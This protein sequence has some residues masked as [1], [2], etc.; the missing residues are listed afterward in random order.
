MEPPLVKVLGLGFYL[1]RKRT[2][3]RRIRAAQAAVLSV[4][5]SS[6]VSRTTSVGIDGQNGAIASG[7][8]HRTFSRVCTNRPAKE[9]AVTGI[10]SSEG[11]RGGCG[12]GKRGGANGKWE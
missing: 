11:N 4:A 8:T 5:K 6:A 9:E 7:L 1:T 2:A 10:W 3:A 12:Y